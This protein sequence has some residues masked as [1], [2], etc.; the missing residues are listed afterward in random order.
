MSY[1]Q[2]IQLTRW[3]VPKTNLPEHR[4]KFIKPFQHTRIDYTGYVWVQ[5]NGRSS[6]MYLLI[7]ICMNI[8][9]IHIELIPDMCTQAFIQALIRFCNIHG[10]PTHIYSDN[11]CSFK[12]TLNGDLIKHC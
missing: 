1:L 8:Q 11:T 6:K 10:V 2:K 7:F 3:Q 4:A 12:M 5:E 9:V